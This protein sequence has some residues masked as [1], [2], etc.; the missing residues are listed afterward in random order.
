MA[1]IAEPAGLQQSSIYYW[2]GSKADILASILE[3]VNRIPLA[4]V[5]RERAAAGPVAVRLYRLVREDVL[6]LCGFPFD[7]NEIHRL[8]E[9]APEDFAAYW[10]ERRRL[11]DEVEALVAEGVAN[12]ELR[13]VDARLAA[14]MLLAGDE[15]TQNWYR[16][17][18]STPYT[19]DAVADHSPRSRCALLA[20]P[21][22]STRR[23]PRRTLSS[24]PRSEL[25]RGP[26]AVRSA[27]KAACCAAPGR[28]RC[29]SASREERLVVGQA[30]R[31][32]LDG[33]R[34]LAGPG[35][36]P[37]VEQLVGPDR[38]E[39]DWSTPQQPRTSG[40]S[41]GSAR[42]GTRPGPCGRRTGSRPDP[43]SRRCRGRRRRCR[44]RS[45]GSR[46]GPGCTSWSPAGGA[47]RAAWRPARRGTR[48][49]ARAPGSARRGRCGVRRRSSRGR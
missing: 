27:A 9:R 41:P 2:F 26:P 10:E 8:A 5:E 22:P 39:A 13:P 31:R 15:A 42:R 38:V 16:D 24:D 37:Q 33:E 17:A 19:P 43:P 34:Q 46:S 49:P 6:A 3:R 45:P 1:Q 40:S 30:E 32:R 28:R 48:R 21:R 14:R 12:G 35:P 44:P 23:A 47:G 4:I 11:D 25:S 29:P 7:I 36:G 18:A 20:E